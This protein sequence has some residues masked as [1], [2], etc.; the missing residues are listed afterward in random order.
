[1]SNYFSFFCLSIFLFYV[2]I[3]LFSCLTLFSYPAI[4]LPLFIYLSSG[5]IHLPSPFYLSTVFETII[6]LLEI[7]S[8]FLSTW[9]LCIF[10]TDYLLSCQSTSH[11]LSVY[12]PSPVHLS[13]FHTIYDV[14]WASKINFKNVLKPISDILK[15]SCVLWVVSIQLPPGIYL[16]PLSA[17]LSTFHRPSIAHLLSIYLPS[18]VHLSCVHHSP[19]HVHLPSFSCPSISLFC[20]YT[21]SSSSI[22]LLIS[23]YHPSGNLHLFP[24]SIYIFLSWLSIFLPLAINLLSFCL[25][26][27]FLDSLCLSSSVYF[28]PFPCSFLSLFHSRYLSYYFHCGKW[29]GS[30]NTRGRSQN[31]ND[32]QAVHSLTRVN[33]LETTACVCC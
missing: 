29:K 31:S 4:P 12:P 19:F 23:T 22:S 21:I 9:L 11:L 13:P 32:I 17:H 25:S 2:Y 7:I 18:I 8:F 1:M 3:F 20:L 30:D 26:T 15:T 28:I 24:L 6:P 27:T 10:L 16:L 5:V 33:H 14:F